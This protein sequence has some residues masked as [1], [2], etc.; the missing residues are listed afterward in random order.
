MPSDLP[1]GSHLTSVCKRRRVCSAS[2]SS[3]NCTNRRELSACTLM[4]SIILTLS[5]KTLLSSGDIFW[6]ASIS[7]WMTQCID[8]HSE[9][10]SLTQEVK[11]EGCPVMAY[12]PSAHMLTQI[13]QLSFSDSFKCR[14]LFVGS[15][16]TFCYLII[17]SFP[18]SK[19]A[20]R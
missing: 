15:L 16:R 13:D 12:T 6:L 4:W 19:E 18:L 17:G 20:L 2:I 1:L 11:P 3:Q 5:C 7:L 14:F 8:S 10:T 9:A